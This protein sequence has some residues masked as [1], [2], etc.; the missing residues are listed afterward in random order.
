MCSE[1]ENCNYVQ[2]KFENPQQ[3][4]RQTT[5][6]CKIEVL[7]VK[8]KLEKKFKSHTQNGEFPPPRSFLKTTVLKHLNSQDCPTC[9]AW[10]HKFFSLYEA[11]LELMFEPA[12]VAH[13]NFWRVC[14][15]TQETKMASCLSSRFQLF[16]TF[17]SPL[18]WSESESINVRKFTGCDILFA[19]FHISF[20]EVGINC[21]PERMCKSVMTHTKVHIIL[22]V[23][24]YK[25]A[26]MLHTMGFKHSTTKSGKK[27]ICSSKIFLKDNFV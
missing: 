9:T 5:F 24:M 11:H 8:L 14:L 25:K 21:A 26:V 10:S 7:Q 19:N 12:L 15:L 6:S 3:E 18:K 1:A 2:Q 27:R 13:W 16:V 23:A 4:N 22:N 17:G 20:Q